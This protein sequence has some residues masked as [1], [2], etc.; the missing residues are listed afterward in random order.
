MQPTAARGSVR[1]VAEAELTRVMMGLHDELAQAFFVQQQALLDRDFVRA[2]RLLAAYR[3]ALL[4]HMR[5]EETAVL[6]RYEALGGDATDAPLRLFLGEHANLRAFVDEFGTRIAALAAKPDD[7]ALLEL[8]DRQATFKNLMLHHDLRERNMLYPFLAARL[9]APEQH[10][11][12]AR[13]GT[14]SGA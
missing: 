1:G 2:G 7:R 13:C 4:A 8:F 10:A 9:P 5:D 3:E 6:P 12:L 11:L 14:R